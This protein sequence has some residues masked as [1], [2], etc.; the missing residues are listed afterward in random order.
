MRTRRFS[1]V[2]QQMSRCLMLLVAEAAEHFY[3]SWAV[4]MVISRCKR[5][6]QPQLRP[7][8][9]AC[10]CLFRDKQLL[11]EL[12]TGTWKG[13][14]EAVLKTALILKVKKNNLSIC[15]IGPKSLLLPLVLWAACGDLYIPAGAVVGGAFGALQEALVSLGWGSVASS[16]GRW[17]TLNHRS[18]RSA[19]SCLAMPT[20]CFLFIWACWEFCYSFR[21]R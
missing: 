9:E 5:L 15:S 17:L 1:S 10:L 16:N 14:R 20:D 2:F 3:V 6:W 19:A 8:E 18:N 4:K 7:G 12:N 11:G 21:I 13:S